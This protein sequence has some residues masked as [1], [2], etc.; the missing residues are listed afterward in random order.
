MTC[1]PPI[2]KLYCTIKHNKKLCVQIHFYEE[3]YSV[4]VYTLQTKKKQKYYSIL[5]KNNLPNLRMYITMK[6]LYHLGCAFMYT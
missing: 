3:K 6:W 1:L 2:V 4:K 5:L